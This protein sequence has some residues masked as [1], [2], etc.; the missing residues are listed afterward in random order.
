MIHTGGPLSS[1]LVLNSDM[2][3]NLLTRYQPVFD[4]LLCLLFRSD[5]FGNLLTSLMS[6]SPGLC[7]G[8]LT[9]SIL[10]FSIRCCVLCFLLTF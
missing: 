2:F 4:K 6:R 8:L 10:T 9:S 7:D 1:Q 5:F 3:G